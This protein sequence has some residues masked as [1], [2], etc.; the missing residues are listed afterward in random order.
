MKIN[1]PVT[2]VVYQEIEVPDDMAVDL[3]EDELLSEPMR[4]MNIVNAHGI[5][6]EDWSEHCS[7]QASA[8]PAVAWI[9]ANLYE[10]RKK[11]GKLKAEITPCFGSV[12]FKEI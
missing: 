9:W 10:L 5:S 11:N 2:F 6:V 3:V 8:S 4:G 12:P 7:A 1:I